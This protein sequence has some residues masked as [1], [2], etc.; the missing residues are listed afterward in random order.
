MPWKVILWLKRIEDTHEVEKIKLDSAWKADALEKEELK[1]K[2]TFNDEFQKEINKHKTSLEEYKKIISE[3]EANEKETWNK[4]SNEEIENKKSEATTK[5]DE[6]KKTM[7]SQIQKE[8]WEFIYTKN[9]DNWDWTSSEVVLFHNNWKDYVRDA[10]YSTEDVLWNEL[11]DIYKELYDFNAWTDIDIEK[12]LTLDF[13]ENKEK[14]PVKDDLIWLKKAIENENA[15]AKESW[16]DKWLTWIFQA[17]IDFSKKYDSKNATKWQKQMMWIITSFAGMAKGILQAINNYWWT[18]I[19]WMFSLPTFSSSQEK[20]NELTAILWLDQ[21]KEAL[22]SDIL[23]PNW[24]EN[25]TWDD[26]DIA[27]GLFPSDY[28]EKISTY[29]EEYIW[30][31]NI[32]D[33]EKIDKELENDSIA[34]S[35][36]DLLFGNTINEV[37]WKVWVEEEL[38]KADVL[39][40]LSY[41]SDTLTKKS[42]IFWVAKNDDWEWMT[43][44]KWWNTY[45][46]SPDW[47]ASLV[48]KAQTLKKYSESNDEFTLEEKILGLGEKNNPQ[49]LTIFKTIMKDDLLIPKE[50]IS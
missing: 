19:A 23:V 25:L 47:N 16:F 34:S 11:T 5:L 26:I 41:K 46:Y 22:D 35:E 12:D 4:L 49:D 7:I 39:Y 30:K 2:I 20:I 44:S 32:L 21:T 38:L 15:P 8:I 48:N 29:M 1:A 9:V 50:T 10:Y 14:Y 37:A 17:A 13:V 3:I 43:F 24:Y 18:E 31:W 27:K 36:I 40:W 45:P 6:V 28:S 42:R 33:N